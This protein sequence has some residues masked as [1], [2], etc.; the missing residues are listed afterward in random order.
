MSTHSSAGYEPTSDSTLDALAAELGAMHVI[1][2][3]LS[4]VSDSDTRRRV[5]SWAH[6]R[7]ITAA[8]PVALPVRPAE[9]RPDHVDDTLEVDSLYELFEGPQ[10]DAAL[11]ALRAAGVEP[12]EP[13][14]TIESNK[15]DLRG[16][17]IGML[18]R[19]V[20][21]GV[22]VLAAQSQTA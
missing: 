10:N 17:A 8:V 19:A 21:R 7:F 9:T 12:D 15:R 16:G 11:L 14:T 20:S 3:A 13:Q 4:D 6:E 1:A 18:I 5:L 22:A 2:K